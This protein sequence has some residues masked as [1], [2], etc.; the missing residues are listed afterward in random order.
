M[1]VVQLLLVGAV[2][3]CGV[4]WC[5][6]AERP[7]PQI[8]AVIERETQITKTLL[9]QGKKKQCVLCCGIVPVDMRR[10]FMSEHY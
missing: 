4:P 8:E 7:A 10:F 9:K 3:V 5:V 6:G 1:V 2:V